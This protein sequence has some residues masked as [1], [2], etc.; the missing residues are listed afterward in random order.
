MVFGLVTVWLVTSTLQNVAQP[1]TSAV[2]AS[3]VL[4]LVAVGAS[5]LVTYR[6]AVEVPRVL[7]G[8]ETALVE[9]ARVLRE[10]GTSAAARER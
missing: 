4:G 10:T 9:R 7:R 3:L 8:W 6:F 2:V 1:A 5:G